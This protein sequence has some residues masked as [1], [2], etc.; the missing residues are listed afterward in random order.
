MRVIILK[1]RYGYLQIYHYMH[2]PTIIDFT[3]IGYVHTYNKKPF[4]CNF[5]I[6]QIN[7][8][9][10]IFDNLICQTVQ[11]VRTGTVIAVTCTVPYYIINETQYFL[12]AFIIY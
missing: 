12:P 7:Q 11:I 3:R 6:Y 2:L 10:F 9:F 5:I 4:M 8:S 1:V